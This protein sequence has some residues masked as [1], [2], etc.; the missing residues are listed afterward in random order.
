MNMDR[1]VKAHKDL[2]FNLVKGD[3]DS[4]ERHREFYDE[5]LAVMDLT[6]EFYL[7]TVKKVFID[8]ALPKGHMSYRGSIIDTGA[9]RRVALMTVE[10][11]KDDITGVGQCHAAHTLCPNLPNSLRKHHLQPSA[12]HYGIFNGARF[13]T[14]IVPAITAFAKRHDLRGNGFLLKYFKR[15]YGARRIEVAPSPAAPAASGISV[16]SPVNQKLISRT[17]I[18]G[19]NANG[20]H[21][22]LAGLRD[23]SNKHRLKLLSKASKL[24]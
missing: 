12:G 9:V 22:F 11:E 16:L 24:P 18:K 7:Q 3:G 6:A 2:F 13:R 23:S 8:H 5:Y 15:I 19:Q 4:A 1:H 21:V 10:G 14:D 20:E 17:Q